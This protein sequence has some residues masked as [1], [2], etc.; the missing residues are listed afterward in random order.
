MILE[1]IATLCAGL[2]AGAAVYVSLVEHPARLQ[3]GLALAVAEFGPSYRRAAVMQA[4]LAVV[5]CVAAVAAWAVGSAAVVLV[6]G[7]LLGAVVPFTLIVILPTNERLLDPTLDPGSVEAAALL[8][9]WGRL[10]ALR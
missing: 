8:A 9:R 3:C 1:L 5:G 2:F 7:L 6:A 4:A 10:H